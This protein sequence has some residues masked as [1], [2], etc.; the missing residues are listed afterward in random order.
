VRAYCP[1]CQRRS[2][3]AQYGF[4]VA[5]L[6]GVNPLKIEGIPIYDGVNHPADLI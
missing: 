5:C 1:S 6:N 2:N 4:N 3:P